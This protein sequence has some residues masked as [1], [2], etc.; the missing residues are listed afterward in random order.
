MGPNISSVDCGAVCLVNQRRSQPTVRGRARYDNALQRGLA[1][2]S[3]TSCPRSRL[4]WFMEFYLYIRMYQNLDR[5]NR[6]EREWSTVPKCT[7]W[8]ARTRNASDAAQRIQRSTKRERERRLT[9]RGT[10]RE[11]TASR[12]REGGISR[13]AMVTRACERDAHRLAAAARR[14]CPLAVSIRPS[15]AS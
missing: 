2:S 11:A 5:E 13:P 7:G 15:G 14:R 4:C 1:V 6:T 10:G 3:K 8:P 12:G 9:A